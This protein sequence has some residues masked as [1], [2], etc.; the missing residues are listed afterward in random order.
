[1]SP[2][3]PAE[4]AR[5]RAYVAGEVDGIYLYEHLAVLE[6]SP[7]LKDV[8][9]QLAAMERR[10]LGLWLDQLRAS[11]ADDSLPGPSRRARFL[12]WLGGRFGAE[13]IAPLIKSL[14]RRANDTYTGDP[15]AEA[16]GLPHDESTQD[17]K[18]TRLNSSH[19]SE[20]RMPSSA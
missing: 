13:T 8:Y 5:Y 1:M 20:S 14:E 3:S 19:M 6:E 12:V 15:I 11:G 10:H 18:S 4:I 17:R 16:A 7:S 2:A 9:Q